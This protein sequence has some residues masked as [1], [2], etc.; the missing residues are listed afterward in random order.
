MPWLAEKNGETVTPEAVPDGTD[1]RCRACGERMRPRGPMQDGRARHFFHVKNLGGSRD[2]GGGG[3]SCEGVAETEEHLKWKSLAVSRLRELYGGVA[4]R[5]EPEV[6]LGENE[7]LPSDADFRDADALVEF[8]EPALPFGR[9]II[10]EVQHRHKDKDIEAVQRDYLALGYSVYWADESDFGADRAHFGRTVLEGDLVPVWPTV[11]ESLSLHERADPVEY[12][13]AKTARPSGPVVHDDVPG[14]PIVQVP[15]SE[16]TRTV[17]RRQFA[18]DAEELSA[19]EIPIRLPPDAVDAEMRRLWRTEPWVNRF[20]PAAR[21][22]YTATARAWTFEDSDDAE[23]EDGTVTASLAMAKWYELSREYWTSRPW[24]ERFNPPKTRQYIADVR[25]TTELRGIRPNILLPEW[26]QQTDE[27]P[28]W[29][30]QAWKFGAQQHRNRHDLQAEWADRLLA[31]I[32]ANTGG[33]QP[34]TARK[35]SIR[36]IL[37]ASGMEPDE[38]DRVLDYLIENGSVSED[39]RGRIEAIPAED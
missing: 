2:G 23:P 1:T 8:T 31:A 17:A 27:T 10:V 38:F 9:G 35:S 34:R 30:R 24:G 12:D 33:V 32:R 7:A 16:W 21:L 11:V 20:R 36:Q 5:C 22:E 37:T 26:W 18:L 28:K 4:D 29:L 39:E 15:R 25:Q 19:P 13:V 6:R 3:G 14:K